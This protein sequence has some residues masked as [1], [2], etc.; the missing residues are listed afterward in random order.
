MQAPVDCDK[1]AVFFDLDLT[2][3]NVDTFRYFLRKHYILSPVRIHYSFYIF[4]FGMLRKL[5][6]ISLKS[7]KENALIGLKRMSKMEVTELG[8]TIF[9]RN[10]KKHIRAEAIKQIELHKKKGDIVYI[11]SASPDIYVRAFSEYL[12]CDGYFCTELEFID[13]IFTGNINGNDLIG[14][15]K[16]EKIEEFTATKGIVLKNAYAYSDHDA[17]I[18]LLNIVGNPVAISPTECLKRVAIKNNWP[19]KYW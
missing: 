18:P 11:V 19:I 4:I 15:E 5:R 16:K 1:A 6:L 17:D 13:D 10:L 14:H 2:I 9:E 7:F 8:H 3:T 12:D